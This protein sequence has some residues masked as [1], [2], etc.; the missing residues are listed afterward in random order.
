MKKLLLLW[1]TTL[2]SNLLIA[3]GGTINVIN[4]PLEVEVGQANTFTFVYNP[5]PP[6]TSSTTYSL[7]YWTI[8]APIS[9]SAI[10][11]NINGQN[12]T[13]YK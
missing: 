3:Q 13:T 12:A 11:G 8:T 5:I 9:G 1:V 6:T 7:N 2:C 10:N 4:S